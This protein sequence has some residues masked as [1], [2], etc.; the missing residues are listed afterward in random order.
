[1]VKVLERSGIQGTDLNIIKAVYSMSI[2]YI[3]LNGEKLKA[4]PLKSEIR[5][6]YSLYP[7]LVNIVLEVLAGAIR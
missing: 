2:A 6:D 1:M 5:Q 3:N 4:I 7:Y